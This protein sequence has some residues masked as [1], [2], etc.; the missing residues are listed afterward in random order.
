MKSDFIKKKEPPIKKS[1]KKLNANTEK[2]K[3]MTLK[4]SQSKNNRENLGK[5]LNF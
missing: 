1:K 4:D 5:E 2:K 3:L